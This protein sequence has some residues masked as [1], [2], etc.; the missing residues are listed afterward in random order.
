MADPR[1]FLRVTERETAKRRPVDVRIRDW[2]EVYEPRD[3]AVIAKQ[4][5]RC[6]D[7]GV[8]FCH[9]GCPLGNLI[10]EWN[11]LVWREDHK[12]AI[13][14]LHRTNNFP[15]FTGRLCPAPCESSCVL[16]INQPAVTIKE[17]EVSVID[18]AF[19]D[20]LVLPHAPERLTGKTVAVVGSGPAGLAAAQQLTRAGHTV[21]VFERDDKIGGLLRYGIPDFKMEKHHIDRRIEQMTA[22]GTRFR[23][24]QNIGTDI[25]WEELR[26]RY[27]AVL[28]ATGSTIPRD[29]DVP[30]RSLTGVHFAMDYLVQANQV[31]AGTEVPGQISAEGKHV[32]I[33]GGGDT[34]ADCLG[35]ATRQGALSVTTLAIGKQPASE[36]TAGQPWPTF[37][38][39]FEVSSAHE[40]FGERKYLASTV[41]FVGDN[42]AI[43]GVKVAD[44][45]I[46]D[47]KRQ[48]KQGTERVLPADL[49]FLAL[50]FTGPENQLLKNQSEI[51]VDNRGNIARNSKWATNLEDVFV[52]GDAGRG[53]SLIV[54]AI[55][56]G[57]AAAAAIDEWLT[58]ETV[59]PKPVRPTDRAISI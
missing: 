50:G 44:T 56:E 38:T 6:M 34:G 15:E 4:A 21:A 28:I 10:P 54:W 25:T 36:R 19:D 13:E 1:G 2:K 9:Q 47:G 30:G 40:E 32:I 39:L 52:A 16:G 18:Q 22:E 8:P 48:P 20:G 58:G 46:V 11:D 29:L 14:R 23:T 33:L 41:E 45:E 43:S 59:L 35:T 37:P 55:A 31:V 3:S 57:R 17:I 24:G 27:D 53:Q 42:G 5:S 49:V 12:G 51:M 7:C 26:S